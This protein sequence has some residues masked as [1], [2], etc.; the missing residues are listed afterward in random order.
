MSSNR[1][2]TIYGRREIVSLQT[3][4]VGI[5]QSLANVDPDVD[6]MYRLLMTIPFNFP[7]NFRDMQTLL[8]VPEKSYAPYNAQATLH[9]YPALWSLLLPVT[10]HGRVSDIW[11]G[12]IFQKLAKYIEIDLFFASPFVRQI[13]NSHNYLADFDSEQ[14]LYQKSDKLIE[15]LSS[16]SLISSTLP[17]KIEELYVYMFEHGYLKL[18]DV[19]LCQEWLTALDAIGYIFPSITQSEE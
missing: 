7:P 5:I 2:N 10:V 3:H 9:F 6:A 13:R 14:D 11:R 12:Y 8:K 4:R 16:L 1:H 19:L 15:K 17:G 18:N